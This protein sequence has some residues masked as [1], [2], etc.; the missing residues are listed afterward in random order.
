MAVRSDRASTDL[1]T[2][3]LAKL[4]DDRW[5]SAHDLADELRW[6][7]A[8]TAPDAD[9]ARNRGRATSRRG[10]TAA[11]TA[12]AALVIATL[13][14]WT[15][16]GAHAAAVT[17]AST[18][19]FPVQPQVD[20]LQDGSFD[21]SEDGEQL[22]YSDEIGARHSP[23]C[24][25]TSIDSTRSRCPVRTAQPA[26]CSRRTASGSR[27][28][29]GRRREKDQSQRRRVTRGVARRHWQGVANLWPATDTIFV[30]GRRPADSQSILPMAASP[31]LSRRFSLTPKSI[32]MLR[33]CCHRATRSCLP[34]TANAIAFRLRCR[35]CARARARR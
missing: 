21:I 10:L 9:A 31:R 18:I 7:A 4:P 19:R 22:V 12:G 14:G 1:L 28:M 33:N 24:A 27:S 11:I 20:Q 16:T 32:I 5:Q 26:R 15:S 35:T 2:K 25:S 6:L 3:C 30:F 34:C 29:P 13:I 8:E 23:A 17:P